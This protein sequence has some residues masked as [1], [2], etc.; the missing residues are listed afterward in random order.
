VEANID[1]EVLQEILYVYSTRGERVRALKMVEEML[2]LFPS[3][4][5]IQKE[6]LVK[7]IDLMKKYH[8]L[9]PR[10]AIHCAVVINQGLEGIIST[11]RDLKTIREI[12]CFHP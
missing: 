6:E 4:Y 7:A 11:D 5:G 9:V 12:E 3:P 8:S 1:T 10:D 2:V